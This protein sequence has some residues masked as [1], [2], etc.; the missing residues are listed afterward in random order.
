S[1]ILR[2]DSFRRDPRL[3]DQM[4]SASERV[5]SSISEGSEQSTDRNYAQYLY[6]SRGSTR[7]IRTQL[8]VARDRH[9]ITETERVCVSAKYD[10][11]ARMLT[12][13]IFETQD[14]RSADDQPAQ[15]ANH[16]RA[17]RSARHDLRPPTDLI[18]ESQ[19]LIPNP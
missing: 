2:R 3:R 13:V 14:R 11:I 9:H 4:A 1:A 10:E 15:H 19:S 8:I 17:S 18:G 7:E 16:G 5:A 6:R 12:G